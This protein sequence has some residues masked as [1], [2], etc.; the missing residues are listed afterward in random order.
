MKRLLILAT[1]AGLA[2]GVANASAQ[3]S[4]EKASCGDKAAGSCCASKNQKATLSQL[5]TVTKD[6]VAAMLRASDVTIIDARDAESFSAGHID[7]AINFGQANL[8]TDKNTKL[9]FYCGGTMCPA[10][11]KAAK[12][13]A[14]QGYK[15]IMVYSGGWADWSK[16][17]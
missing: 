15:N 12:K 4:K 3:C 2:F 10:A 8:P 1:A 13:A 7:G 5:K 6:E 14:E 11:A 16:N 17:S 9:V